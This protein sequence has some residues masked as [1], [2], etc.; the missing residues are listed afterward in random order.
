MFYCTEVLKY[1]I[2]IATNFTTQYSMNTVRIW[3]HIKI[4]DL[5]PI[6]N[7]IQRLRP[8]IARE[9]FFSTLNVCISKLYSVWFYEPCA[10]SGYIKQSD[11]NGNVFLGYVRWCVCYGFVSIH[12]MTFPLETLVFLTHSP[13]I[14]WRLTSFS[15]MEVGS[16]VN[17]G[18]SCASTPFSIALFTLLIFLFYNFFCD[19]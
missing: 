9:F 8:L 5:L 6:A 2:E 7:A 3:T 16:K 1:N 11:K 14:I 4:I 12:Q 13:I 17:T 10:S 18:F 19:T 15:I